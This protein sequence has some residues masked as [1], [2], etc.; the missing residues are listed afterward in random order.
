MRLSKYEVPSQVHALK[1]LAGLA[2]A[3]SID[4][5]IRATALRI[6]NHLEN[7]DEA[8]ELEAIFNAVKHG[9][10]RVP[11]LRNGVRYV[12]DNRWADHFTAPK[13]L[14]QMCKDGMCA[15]D[16]DGHAALIAALAASI[17]FMVGLRAWGPRNGKD[18]EHVYAV[19]MLPKH[20]GPSS[21]VVGLDST[22]DESKVGWEPPNG[23]VL[24]AWLDVES[25]DL[26][27]SLSHR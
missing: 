16:C 5:L 10:S 8:A 4:P 23:R 12:S 24:T 2:Q 15:E 6:T 22:V 13:R 1:A 25:A 3:G 7:K 20:G 9:D 18:Y 14:L 19:A 17:G 26:A 21:R 11:A 27:R